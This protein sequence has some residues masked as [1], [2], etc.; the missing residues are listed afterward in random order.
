[1]C[2]DTTKAVLKFQNDPLSI[3]TFTLNFVSFGCNLVLL[4]L[5]PPT[6]ST[7]NTTDTTLKLGTSVEPFTEMPQEIAVC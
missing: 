4:L 2:L 1:M 6:I 3:K 5:R 7:Q